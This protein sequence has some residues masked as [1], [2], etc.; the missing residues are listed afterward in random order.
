MVILCFWGSGHFDGSQ[1]QLWIGQDDTFFLLSMYIWTII[2]NLKH[3]H[4]LSLII[5][6]KQIKQIASSKCH[7]VLKKTVSFDQSHSSRN[8][9]KRKGEKEEGNFCHM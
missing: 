6:R 5:S 3:V 2:I 4:I 7:F 1:D 8:L 9:G